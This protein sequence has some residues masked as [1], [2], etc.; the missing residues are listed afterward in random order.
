MEKV[1]TT[2]LF[3][4]IIIFALF[5]G[6]TSYNISSSMQTLFILTCTGLLLGMFFGFMLC[7][8]RTQ[9][10]KDG[11]LRKEPYFFALLAIL[12]IMILGWKVR[13]N[14]SP[15]EKIYFC[16]AVGVMGFVFGAYWI[17]ISNYI[18]KGVKIGNYE[19]KDIIIGVIT[20][21]ALKFILNLI[22]LLIFGETF[23][24]K[25]V[26]FLISVF[27]AGRVI[28]NSNKR[29]ATPKK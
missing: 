4:S 9:K 11:K 5:F 12:L 3:S 14:F 27:V 29:K 1:N 7:W 26:A 21:F 19:L 8:L 28:E 20:F 18:K 10:N 15:I 17:S 16:L 24:G 13:F 22:F 6:I 23:I 25:L 2:L